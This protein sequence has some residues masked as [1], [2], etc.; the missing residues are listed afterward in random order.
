MLYDLAD[1]Y[2]PNWAGSY[3]VGSDVM[4]ACVAEDFYS[5]TNITIRKGTADLASTSGGLDPSATGV[6]I[7]TSSLAEGKLVIKLVSVQCSD[8]GTYYCK[9]SGVGTV[10]D[11]KISLNVVSYNTSF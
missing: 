11:D 10:T 9:S 3:P 5:L 4:I 2:F 1:I 8:S 6:A 7:V